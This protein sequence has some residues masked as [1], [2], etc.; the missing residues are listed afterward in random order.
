MTKLGNLSS[1]NDGDLSLFDN[2]TCNEDPDL[3]NRM[4]SRPKLLVNSGV[5]FP[6]TLSDDLGVTGE[7]AEFF[8][9]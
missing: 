3:I 5:V 6:K 7:W 2:F 9:D 8:E 1:L 4:S